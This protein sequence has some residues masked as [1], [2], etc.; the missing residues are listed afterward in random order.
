MNECAEWAESNVHI[1]LSSVSRATCFLLILPLCMKKECSSNMLVLSCLYVVHEWKE[2]MCWVS[3]VKCA[4]SIIECFSSNLFSSYL[5]FMHG[6]KKECAERIFVFSFVFVFVFRCWLS[7]LQNVQPRLGSPL[8]KSPPGRRHG[9][10]VRTWGFPISFPFVSPFSIVLELHSEYD[11][12]QF[13]IWFCG[14]LCFML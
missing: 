7:G 11:V 6:M 12:L 8:H 2:W 5:A 1:I 9:V 13:R 3:R 10:R 4:Y 14:F